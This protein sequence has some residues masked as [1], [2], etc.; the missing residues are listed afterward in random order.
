MAAGLEHDVAVVV[1]ADFDL[2]ITVKA[3]EGADE[4][5]VAFG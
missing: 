4:D 5:A 2:L 1:T 3:D